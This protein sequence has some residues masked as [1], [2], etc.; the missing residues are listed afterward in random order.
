MKKLFF[1]FAVLGVMAMIVL[2]SSLL[3]GGFRSASFDA[4]DEKGVV[5]RDRTRPLNAKRNVAIFVHEGVELLDF[6]GPGEVF[7][8]A[9]QSQA[10]NV[11]TVAATSEEITSQRFVTIKPQYTFANC[12]PPDIIVL[13]GGRTDVPLADSKV[14]EWI[15]KSSERAEVMMSVCTGA[16]LL[17]ESGLL[18]GKEATTHWSAIESLKQQAPKTTV[19]ENRRFVDN[20]KVVTAAG[21]SAGIDAALHVVDRLLGREV[22]QKTARYMEYKW[23]PES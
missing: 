21:V 5:A 12:P 13:P 1:A 3:I 7:A 6:S 20:G 14:I 9:G 11:Y 8:S 17:L 16:F 22:A 2:T 4:S 18:D 23:E 15:K 19:R 10:F